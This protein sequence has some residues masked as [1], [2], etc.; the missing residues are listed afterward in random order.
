[1]IENKTGIKIVPE[2]SRKDKFERFAL[3]FRGIVE[4]VPIGFLRISELPAINK[5]F[6]RIYEAGRQQGLKEAECKPKI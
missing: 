4:D 2:Y 5:L 3:N 1:M 6:E